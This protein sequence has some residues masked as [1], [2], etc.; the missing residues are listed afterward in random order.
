MAQCYKTNVI[1]AQ[2]MIDAFTPLLKKSIATP[3]I[4]NVSSG[5]GSIEQRLN[6]SSPIYRMSE[7]QYRAS[8]SAL[9]MV[10]ADRSVE[11]AD[12]GIKVFS[13]CPGFTVSNLSAMNTADK[14]AKPTSEGAAPIVPL[15]EGKRDDKN[16][17]FLYG[18]D[19]QYGW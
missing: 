4:D 3:R 5:V 6:P 12:A 15:L 9:N 7:I 18:F 8:K 13:Y 19:E 10:T 16:G 2:L 1:G 11:L 17:G 14:G